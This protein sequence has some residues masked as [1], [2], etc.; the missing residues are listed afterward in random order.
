[1]DKIDKSESLVFKIA[2]VFLIFTIITIA[3]S[4]YATYINQ[5]VAYEKQCEQSIRQIGSYLSDLMR[6]DEKL[7]KAYQDYYMAHFAENDLPYDVDEYMTAYV[8]YQEMIHEKYPGKTLGTD[9]TINE[10]DAETQKMFFRYYHVFW[11]LTFEKACK[12]FGLAYTYYLVPKE[13]EYIMVYMLD[14]E[15][16]EKNTDGTKCTEGDG[17]TPS[18]LL[19]LG[20]EY[21]DDPKLYPVMWEAWFSGRNPEGYQI[22]D[23]SWGHTYAYYTPLLIN[24][25]KLGLIGTEINVES[26]N[27][28]IIMDVLK[29]IGAITLTL[30]VCMILMLLIINRRYI[31]RITSLETSVRDYTFNK[32]P[33]IADKIETNVLGQDEISLLSIQTA[34][35]I[36]DLEKHIQF[37]AEMAEEKER[38]GT[39]LKV[40]T[41]IQS[42]MMPTQFPERSDFELY[43]TMTPAKEVGGDFYDFFMLDDDHLAL[44]IAD[45]SGK[46]IPAALFM[47]MSKIL[48][49]NTSEADLLPSKILEEV[50]DELCENN[51]AGMFVT[52]WL[53]ILTISTGKLTFANAGHEYP[54]FKRAKGSYELL[55]ADN[56]PPLSVMEDMTFTDDTIML[57]PGDD[58]FLY[59]DGVPEAKSP[60]GKRFGTD[61]MISLLNEYSDFS[62]CEM[63][64]TIEDKI[65]E[66][67]DTEDLFDDVTMMRIKYIGK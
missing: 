50:N 5:T 38:I 61:R 19:Y 1:M 8:S 17:K 32:D 4:S 21:Y 15:R 30:V 59:T 35:M 3:V 23:N 56:C 12:D 66:F 34:N 54:A 31:S 55:R 18:G 25:K 20:D 41:K 45:V 11:L 29:Q 27:Q 60:A 48:I 51:T 2:S 33:A 44:V 16:S 65:N 53:G 37:I 36:R 47:I 28:A 52:A 22:W 57:E 9:L 62:P 43:A 49:R 13:E 7:F 63:L 39:E 67:D 42:D 26:V 64:K 14:G 58:L 46:G 6:S 10:L 40:A 24:G